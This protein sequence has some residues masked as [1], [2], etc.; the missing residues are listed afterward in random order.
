MI[1]EESIL[2]VFVISRYNVDCSLD[3]MFLATLQEYRKQK[4]GTLLWQYSIEVA[5]KVRDGSVVTI[6]VAD[7]GPKYSHLRK[8]KPLDTYPKICQ[9][10]ATVKGTQKI[11]KKCKFKVH[12]TVSYSEYVFDRKKYTEHLGDENAVYQVAAL[13]L[14][15]L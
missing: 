7:L 4:L 9:V 6:S 11:V 3:L 10:L 1:V 15:E 5:R 14:Y 12:L 13:P 2:T 8:P